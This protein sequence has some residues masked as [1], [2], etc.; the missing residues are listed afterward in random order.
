MPP[1]MAMPSEQRQ[2]PESPP[3]GARWAQS[4]DGR[5][6][7][8]SNVVSRRP[9]ATPK[10]MD[11]IVACSIDCECPRSCFPIRWWDCTARWKPRRQALGISKHVTNT[12]GKQSALGS[13]PATRLDPKFTDFLPPWRNAKAEDVPV[14]SRLPE[15]R[16]VKRASPPT[17][18][19]LARRAAGARFRRLSSMK[20]PESE[21][22]DGKSG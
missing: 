20:L 13:L 8:R 12:Q 9:T 19:Q 6:F 21:S 2:A 1:D 18:Q 14:N 3:R 16:H 22:E 4:V 7:A 17:E 11:N 15:G 10:I 5:A